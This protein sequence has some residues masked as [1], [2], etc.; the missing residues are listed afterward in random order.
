M[1]NQHSQDYDASEANQD[2]MP[3]L[4]ADAEMGRMYA[5]N[6]SQRYMQ[7]YPAMGSMQQPIGA[8]P[9]FQPFMNQY[10]LVIN[11]NSL[12]SML[13]DNRKKLLTATKASNEGEIEEAID[14]L[15]V[16]SK[17]LTFLANAADLQSNS[18]F[19][20]R[21]ERELIS[22]KDLAYFTSILNKNSKHS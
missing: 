4:I 22:Q 12:S 7:N 10:P 18:R 3:P 9:M 21:Q 8:P 6:K 1:E 19:V 5:Q 15:Q 17:N 20:L 13:N 2:S 16:V 11:L 14:L